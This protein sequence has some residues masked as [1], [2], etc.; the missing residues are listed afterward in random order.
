MRDELLAGP[1]V[2]L[3]TAP[4]IYFLTG[5]AKRAPIVREVLLAA[6]RGE[7][8]VVVSAVTE[9]ELLVAPLRRLDPLS[10]CAP[11]HDLLNGPPALDVQPVT[12]QIARRAAELRARWNLRLAD[13]LIAAT[14][15]ETGCTTLL[16]NDLQFRRLEVE[17]LAY[18]HLD[19]LARAP[20]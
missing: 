3:D 19:D 17:G 16:G 14:A 5:D 10:S 9:A 13:A 20:S 15:A 12:R 1:R 2:A 11:V 8:D 6:A 7:I 18:H 4:L